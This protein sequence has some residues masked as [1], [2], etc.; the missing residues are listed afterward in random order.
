[1]LMKEINDYLAKVNTHY[2]SGIAT[3][4]MYRADLDT[5]L[6]GLTSG[7]EVTNEPSKVTDCGM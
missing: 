4:H 3:E 7:V 6:R 1:M 2:K 5:L